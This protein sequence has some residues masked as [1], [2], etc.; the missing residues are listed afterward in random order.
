MVTI[1]RETS[2]KQHTPILDVAYRA[3]QLAFRRRQISQ[4]ISNEHELLREEMTFRQTQGQKVDQEYIASRENDIE[5]EA[6]HQEKEAQATYGMLRGTDPRVAPL[7]RGLAVWGLK[8]DDIG[9]AN[10]CLQYR[11]SLTLSHLK[12]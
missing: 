7:R 1:A 5:Q 6:R 12:V 11:Y 10:I 3:R 9:S 2:T 8:A 4:W